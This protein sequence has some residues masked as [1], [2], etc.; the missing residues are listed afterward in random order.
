[1]HQNCPSV[2]TSTYTTGLLHIIEIIV[3]DTNLLAA[4]AI[5]VPAKRLEFQVDDLNSK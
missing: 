4:Y 5:G 3:I 1:M 2:Q